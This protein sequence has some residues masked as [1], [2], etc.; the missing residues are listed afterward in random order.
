MT[1]GVIVKYD[2]KNRIYR[3]I[4]NGFLLEARSLDTLKKRVVSAIIDLYNKMGEEKP[5]K[6]I[7]TLEIEV[8]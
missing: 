8:K 7:F 5:E 4:C 1:Y 2:K 6:I 3:A